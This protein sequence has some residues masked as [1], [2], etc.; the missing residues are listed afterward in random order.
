MPRL[1]VCPLSGLGDAL[2]SHRPSHLVTLL[3]PEHM[4]A[5]PQGFDPAR[6]LRL[7]VQDVSEPEGADNP[8]GRPDID[9]LLAFAR[10]WDGQAPFLI[11][12]WAGISRSMASAFTVL[13]DR[14]GHGREIE[15][16]LAMRR[17]A[18]HAS[19]NRLLVRH[20]DE[21]LGREGRMI[22]ALTVMGPPLMMTEGVITAFPLADL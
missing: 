10:S 14:L 18:P 19:P 13:C 2:E 3:S 17:R 7:G 11:H 15:I 20:A 9:R 5:T 4:I 6:H 1:L 16:A 8:P 12:C 22:T 21:A